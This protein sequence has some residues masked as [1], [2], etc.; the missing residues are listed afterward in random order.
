MLQIGHS[1]LGLGDRSYYPEETDVMIA[2]RQFM[3]D[4]ARALTNA[5][6]TIDDDVNATFEFEKTIAMVTN[7]SCTY[8]SYYFPH[9]VLLD[10]SRINCTGQ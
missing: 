8:S 6:S 4:L 2:Y 9:I 5:T 10:E 1:D 3:Q 7:F